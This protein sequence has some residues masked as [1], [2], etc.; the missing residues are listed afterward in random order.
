MF[1]VVSLVAVFVMISIYLYFRAE[2]LQSE[3]TL[4]KREAQ[5]VKK[6]NGFLI[7]AMII[8]ANKNEEFAKFRLQEMKNN[9][10]E[11][12]A[13]KLKEELEYI[14]LLTANYGTIYKE[15]LKGNVQLKTVTKNCLDNYAAGTFNCFTLFINNQ[16]NGLKRMWLSNNLQ[17]FISLIEALLLQ[18]N[19]KIKT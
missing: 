18:L 11:K 17:G 4:S 3:L 5:K 6:E 12:L 2:N 1:I 7:D 13:E 19:K 10:D 16:D 9:M 14:T 15:C 8:S